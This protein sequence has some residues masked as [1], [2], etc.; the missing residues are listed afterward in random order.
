MHELAF[1]ESRSAPGRIGTPS[2]GDARPVCT[3]L[4]EFFLEFGSRLVE[5]STFELRDPVQDRHRYAGCAKRNRQSVGVDDKLRFEIRD[6]FTITGRGTV[7]TG[8]LVSGAAHV[9]DV[10][11]L[12]HGG[13]TVRTKIVGVEMGHSPDGMPFHLIGLMLAGIRKFDVVSG[14][15][16]LGVRSD[17]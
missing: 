2:N 15:H 9:D 4:H 16:V 1:D 17:S 13:G 8:D 5:A 12:V 11:D 14:D 6:S 10:V 3:V 7:V